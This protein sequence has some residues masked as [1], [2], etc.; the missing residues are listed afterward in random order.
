MVKFRILAV[1]LLMQSCAGDQ[2]GDTPETTASNLHSA[3]MA[4]IES[5]L[6]PVFVLED[7]TPPKSIEELMESSGVPGLCIAFVDDGQLAWSRSYGYADLKD[8]IPVSSQTVFRAASL[9]KPLTAMV[10]LQMVAEGIIGMEED[11]SPRLSGWSLPDTPFTREQ[12]VTVANLIGH[13]SGIGNDT[14][15]GYPENTDMPSIE[16]ILRGQ[17]LDKPLRFIAEPGSQ[18]RYSN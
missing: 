6:Y 11:I 2:Q 18:T 9:S 1:L 3:H 12:K 16:E 15:P 13:R 17:V 5:S 7:E 14:H 10:S 8:S 4:R